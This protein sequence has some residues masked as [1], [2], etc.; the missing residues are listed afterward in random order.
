MK[1]RGSVLDVMGLTP[2]VRLNRIARYIVDE[3]EPSGQLTK[4]SV[5]VEATTRNTG[6]AFALR[7]RNIIGLYVVLF[8]L[9]LTSLFSHACG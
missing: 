4:G 2:M 1:V 5:I 9:E 8:G 6:I 3:A 7:M